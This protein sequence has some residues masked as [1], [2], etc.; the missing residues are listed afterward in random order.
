MAPVFASHRDTETLLLVM[1]SISL[2][3][4][5]YAATIRAPLTMTFGAYEGLFDKHGKL[6]YSLLWLLA[7]VLIASLNIGTRA[8]IME[9]RG[10]RAADFP[11]WPTTDTIFVIA[12]VLVVYGGL[13]QFFYE[14]LPL[15]RKNWKLPYRAKISD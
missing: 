13:V 8:K 11:E 5:V 6:F 10:I 9:L 1:L 4:T 7:R 2:L 14:L 12:E 15:V 3:I